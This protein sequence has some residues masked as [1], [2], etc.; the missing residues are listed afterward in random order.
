[1]ACGAQVE[2]AE[3]VMGESHSLSVIE[4]I[5]SIIGAAMS[6]GL[7]HRMQMRLAALLSVF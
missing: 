1:M 2:D 3:A 4:I 7:C 6:Y 5:A